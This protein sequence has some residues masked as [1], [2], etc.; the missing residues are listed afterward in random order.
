MSALRYYEVLSLF[1]LAIIL[2][3][4]VPRM[5]G[6]GAP[7][8]AAER[9]AAVDRLFRVAAEFADGRRT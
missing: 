5:R 1:K 8:L 9:A 6:A 7:D 2:E 4:G 3:G